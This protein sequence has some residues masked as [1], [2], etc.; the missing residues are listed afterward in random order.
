MPGNSI[1][2][3]ALQNSVG[4]YA[5]AHGLDPSRKLEDQDPTSLQKVYAQ[6]RIFDSDVQAQYVD[7][8]PL[9]MDKLI[10]VG[11]DVDP[12]ILEYYRLKC[13]AG[14]LAMKARLLSKTAC[15]YCTSRCDEI[16]IRGRN[17]PSPRIA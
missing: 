15:N 3:Q 9:K 7:Y 12:S 10:F 6:V 11:F 17:T 16:M 2:T 13:G 8:S 4:N 14:S 5:R 1:L